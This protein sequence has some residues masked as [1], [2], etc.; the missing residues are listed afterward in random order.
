MVTPGNPLQIVPQIM[1]NG[2]K[3]YG[4]ACGNMLK[5]W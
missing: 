1:L 4:N 3:K 2:G 5:L